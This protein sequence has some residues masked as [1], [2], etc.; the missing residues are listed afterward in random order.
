MVP[1]GS[2]SE[3]YELKSELCYGFSFTTKS[4]ISY[5]K[6]TYTYQISHFYQQLHEFCQFLDKNPDFFAVP[7]NYAHFL[8]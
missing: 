2:H 1:S 3:G 5:I 8:P 4:S 7:K 6:L